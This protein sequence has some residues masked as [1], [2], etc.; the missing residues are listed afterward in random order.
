MI[1]FTIWAILNKQLIEWTN[2]CQVIRWMNGP[3]CSNSAKRVTHL[4]EIQESAVDVTM[5][6]EC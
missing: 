4:C 3:T 2:T 5:V 1:Y 6:A